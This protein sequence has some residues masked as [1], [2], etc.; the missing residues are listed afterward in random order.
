MAK[1][2]KIK[3]KKSAFEYTL[4]I[5]PDGSFQISDKKNKKLKTKGRKTTPPI[6]EVLNTRIITIM[7]AKDDSD[8]IYVEPPGKWYQLS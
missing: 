2:C 8:L 7:E 4:A 3:S 5:R 6:K 1:F